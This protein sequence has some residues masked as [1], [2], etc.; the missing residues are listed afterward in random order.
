MKTAPTSTKS[1]QKNTAARHG[2]TEKIT[3]SQF[4]N[5]RT[6]LSK[7]LHNSCK[8]FRIQLLL[9]FKYQLVFMDHFLIKDP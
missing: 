9:P 3:K 7:L 2:N 1:S 5:I 8:L 4:L 6:A